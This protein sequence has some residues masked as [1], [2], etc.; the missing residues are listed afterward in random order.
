MIETLESTTLE[1]TFERLPLVIGDAFDGHVFGA[2]QRPSACDCFARREHRH[3]LKHVRRL[4]L[5]GHVSKRTLL[6]R[7]VGGPRVGLAGIEPTTER[8]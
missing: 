2:R 3:L 4:G 8:L 5:D 6:A 1:R 7:V